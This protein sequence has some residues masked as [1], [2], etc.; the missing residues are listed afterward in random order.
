MLI[1]GR[2]V[3]HDQIERDFAEGLLW[4]GAAGCAYVALQEDGEQGLGTQLCEPTW[5]V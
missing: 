1:V 4:I 3:F 5:I 2:T